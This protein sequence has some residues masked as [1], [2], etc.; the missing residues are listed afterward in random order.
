[1]YW[2]YV[3]IFLCFSEVSYAADLSGKL[4]DRGKLLATGGVSQVEGAGGAGLSTWALISGYGS[5]RGIGL[6]THYSYVALDDFT[7]NSVGLSVGLFDRAEFTYARQWFDTGDAGSRLGLGKG[8]NFTQDIIGAKVRLFGDAIYAQ[9]KFLPQISAGVQYKNAGKSSI[10]SAIGAVRDDDLDFY[11][12][13]TKAYLS[14]SLIVSATARLTRANHFGLLGFGGHGR[15]SRSIEFEGSLV[16]MLKH[17]LVIGADYRS[18]PDNLGFAEEG[19]AK[20]IYLAWFLNKYVSIT[21][22]GVDLGPIALQGRQQG[23]YVSLQAGF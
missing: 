16:Y 4:F 6:N 10:L 21:L 7:F 12:S 17:N 2:K 8:F 1:M 13:T 23:F 14:Q 19:D 11:L 20:A 9:D 3:L 18:K 5:E 22:G 15:D